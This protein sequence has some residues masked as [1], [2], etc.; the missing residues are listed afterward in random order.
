MTYVSHAVVSKHSRLNQRPLLT[1]QALIAPTYFIRYFTDPFC[2]D[3]LLAIATE[4]LVG[5]VQLLQLD[6]ALLQGLIQAGLT[7][8]GHGYV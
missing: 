7:R 4:V 5:P 2:I 1:E 6:E 8:Q 3:K